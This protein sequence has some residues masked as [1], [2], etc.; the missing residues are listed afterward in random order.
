MRGT[1][2]IYDGTASFFD[3]SPSSSSVA[4]TMVATSIR[5]NDYLVSN[6]TTT[7]NPDLVGVYVVYV[8]QYEAG[9]ENEV[10]NLLP[11]LNSETIELNEGTRAAIIIMTAAGV[12]TFT[13]LALAFASRRRNSHRNERNSVPL[14]ASVPIT[15][16]PPPS[17]SD[18]SII[19]SLTEMFPTSHNDKIVQGDKARSQN[20]NMPKES[21]VR[22]SERSL[23]TAAEINCRGTMLLENGDA[24]RKRTS[25]GD[26]ANTKLLVSTESVSERALGTVSVVDASEASV[27]PSENGFRPI[28]PS[29]IL[30]Y[31]IID[32]AATEEEHV[33]S[34]TGGFP[35]FGI[36]SAPF[37]NLPDDDLSSTSNESMR[38]VS[39]SG[40]QFIRDLIWIENRISLE[41]SPKKSLGEKKRIVPMTIATNE[42][43]EAMSS[44]ACRDCF[45]PSG[46]LLD[47]IDII[48]TSDGPVLKSIAEGSVL[49][50]HA[51]APARIVSV[52][53]FDTRNSTADF[54]ISLLASTSTPIHKLTVLHFGS[55]DC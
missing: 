51:T 13:M 18:L 38:S 44:V 48:S 45:I 11:T 29:S 42:R 32:T 14:R 20:E 19:S 1:E 9:D 7:G 22:S 30:P 8:E 53:G 3:R 12:T 33:T 6:I 43:S 10:K 37:T 24:S 28:S 4:K 2:I 25:Y 31:S 41:N 27:E 34:K 47:G 35:T 40:S 46:A 23:M 39:T 16:R 36:T 50:S 15:T 5:F 55:S 26:K 52:D 49:H 17:G 21:A 54:V